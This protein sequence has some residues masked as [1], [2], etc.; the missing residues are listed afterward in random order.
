MCPKCKKLH[1]AN[2]ACEGA[3]DVSAILSDIE[4]GVGETRDGLK[5][6]DARVAAYEQ[7][8]KDIESPLPPR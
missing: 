1:A 5:T 4:R 7:R 8:L 2:I 6:V 3:R